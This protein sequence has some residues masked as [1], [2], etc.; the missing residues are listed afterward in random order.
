MSQTYRRAPA[1][2]SNGFYEIAIVGPEHQDLRKSMQENF[3]PDA[4]YLGGPVDTEL[5]LLENK[6]V[7]G[8]TYI[9][10]C[11]DKYC[12]LPVKETGMAIGLI[13]R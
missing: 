12:K 7:Q 13:E 5:S 4:I 10:V 11:R 6:L 3:I 9:Y 8:E 1:A 2:A